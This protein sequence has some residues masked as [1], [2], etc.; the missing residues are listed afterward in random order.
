MHVR[1]KVFTANSNRYIELRQREAEAVAIMEASCIGGECKRCEAF[2]ALVDLLVEARQLQPMQDAIV[3]DLDDVIENMLLYRER[4]FM[5]PWFT[6]RI[7]GKMGLNNPH[8][9]LDENNQPR[10]VRP[11][12]GVPWLYRYTASKE[13]VMWRILSTSEIERIPDN[14]SIEDQELYLPDFLKSWAGS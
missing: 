10:M 11:V 14:L 4:E 7:K 5:W 1:S 8:V 3:Q 12:D 13:W 2:E 6:K 9:F